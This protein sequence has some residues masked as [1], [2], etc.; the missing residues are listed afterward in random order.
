MARQPQSQKGTAT[1]KLIAAGKAVLTGPEEKQQQ[2]QGAISEER[3]QMI[4]EA[5][6]LIAEQRGFQGDMAMEDW[7]QAEVEV[8]AQLSAKH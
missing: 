4:T 3:Y 5:A 8:D 7:L 6:Y 1:K 2:E